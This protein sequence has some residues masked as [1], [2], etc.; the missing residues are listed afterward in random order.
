MGDAPGATPLVL[1][2]AIVVVA[3][4]FSAFLVND[5]ICLVLTPLVLELTPRL[6]RDPSRIC[7]RSP[8]ASNVGSVATITGNPQNMIIGSLSQIPYGTFAAA[9]MPV[10]IAGACPDRR[11]DRDL[12]PGR[13]PGRR[14][15]RAGRHATGPLSPLAGGEVA[16]DRDCEWWRCFSPVRQ[17]AKVAIV[18]GAL[19]LFTRRIKPAKVYREIDWPLLVMFAGLFVV[20][21]GFEQARC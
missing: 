13:V 14:P 3:G 1:L 18:G 7:S 21:G 8:M 6:R 16:G 15:V 2:A 19:L 17:S 11:A 5:A 12:L 10:A 4:V 20:V 9:L